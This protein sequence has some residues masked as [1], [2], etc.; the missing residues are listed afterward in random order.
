MI[1]RPVRRQGPAVRSGGFHSD[2]PSGVQRPYSAFP[3]HDDMEE[4]SKEF[5]GIVNE[6]DFNI[7]PSRVPR[8]ANRP[9]TSRIQQHMA[10]SVADVED[11]DLNASQS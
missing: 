7:S 9:A 10:E 2:M 3:N 1:K 11:I 4:E 8:A 5:T 6:C